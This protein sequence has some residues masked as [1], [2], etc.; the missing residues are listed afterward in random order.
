MTHHV[1]IPGTDSRKPPAPTAFPL[2]RC[3]G[4]PLRGAEMCRMIFEHGILRTSAP[5]L[6]HYR[7]GKL[8]LERGKPSD[9]L[10][11]IRRGYARR[12]EMR[13]DGKRVLFGLAI[14]GDFAGA[15][16]GQNSACDLEAA[17]DLEI[18][19]YDSS[20]VNWQLAENP[21]MRQTLLQ[22]LDR[23]HHRFLETL[24]RYGSLNSRERIIAFLLMATDFMP[25]EPLPD[26]SLIL[27]MEIERRDWADLTNTA[28]E[29]ISRTLRYLEEKA[30]LSSLSPYRFRLHDLDRLAHIAGV[31]PVRRQKPGHDRPERLTNPCKAP[32]SASP[33]TAVNAPIYRSATLRML[34]KP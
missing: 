33:M 2:G 13:K 12:S 25:T 26:G 7:K 28:V 21:R 23:Q 27:R 11:V 9:F 6:R 24:W 1:R 8:I 29:T 14:P 16:S 3:I 31:D 19:A 5:P 32:V 17:T 30:L 34:R 20:A 10:G 4:C 15:L 22:D 18:C